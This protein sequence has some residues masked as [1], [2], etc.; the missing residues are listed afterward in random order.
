M[1]CLRWAYSVAARRRHAPDRGHADLHVNSKGPRGG[2]CRALAGFCYRMIEE[3]II[4]S[5]RSS[6]ELRLSEPRP[7][8]A[9]YPVDY[10]RAGLKDK[11]IAASSSKIY[12][13]EPFDLAAF[14]EDLAANRRGWEGMK[15]WSSVE[16]DFAL[17]CKSDGLGH[18][19]LEVTLKSGVYEDDWCVKA[20]IHVEVGQ[21]EETAAKVRR[22]LHVER[23]G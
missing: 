5:S 17:S 22:F 4:K 15:Q 13:H 21:L 2:R 8:G 3:V 7:P 10:L 23:A 6:G 18:A 12:I 9:R 19:A 11:E 16:G 14:F 1:S 20:V